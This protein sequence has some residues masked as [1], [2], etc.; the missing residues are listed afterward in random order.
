MKRN[1]RVVAIAAL[2]LSTGACSWLTDF[3]Q[4]PSV[5]E[6]QSLDIT[7]KDTT[8][9]FRGNPQGS[10]SIA[11]T[12]VADYEVSHRRLP[13]VVDS[14]NGIANPEPATQASV[15]R[16]AKYY[17]INCA[18]C[19]GLEGK[20]DGP[21]AR[22]NGAPNLT[23]EAIVAFSDGHYFGKIRNGGPIM[24]TFNRIP[25][26][27]RWHVVNYIRGLQGK[28]PSDIVVQKA[29]FGLPGVTGE[30]LPGPSPLAPHIAP[31]V[32]PVYTAT[33]GGAAHETTTEKRQ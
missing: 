15:T 30:A 27:D 18:V 1:W 32:K 12:A 11:G 4:Q 16:G 17:Q 5:K 19:H 33:P 6:W 2:S 26:R 22:F 23:T 3:R 21:V 14:M 24:P 10:V 7:W 25:E 28:L 20:G 9:P 31:F 13:V 29:P 8:T